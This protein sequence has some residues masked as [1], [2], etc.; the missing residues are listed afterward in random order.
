MLDQ[1]L[2]RIYSYGHSILLEE[3][4][5]E[6]GREGGKEDEEEE[7]EEEGKSVLGLALFGASHHR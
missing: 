6:E 1:C 2:E 3:E 5:E 7:E 4:E